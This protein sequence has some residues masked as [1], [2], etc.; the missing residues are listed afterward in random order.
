MW[1]TLGIKPIIAAST[2][3]LSSAAILLARP[4]LATFGE[5][6]SVVEFIWKLVAAAVGIGAAW[7]LFRLQRAK[8]RVAEIEE[9]KAKIEEREALVK[10]Q[11]LLFE[12]ALSVARMCDFCE[13]EP[14]F[15]CVVPDKLRPASCPKKS[16]PPA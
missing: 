5:F 7:Y 3:A 11:T 9:R 16:K 13:S 6:A 12:Q 2:A 14:K 15:S 4:I 8:S 10:E 1:E